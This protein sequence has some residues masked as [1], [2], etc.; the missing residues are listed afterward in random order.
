MHMQ[1]PFC[2]KNLYSKPSAPVD[3]LFRLVKNITNSLSTKIILIIASDFNINMQGS[4]SQKNN[5]LRFMQQHN[6]SLGVDK[7]TTHAGSML[8]HFWIHN[9]NHIAIKFIVLDTYWIDHF[10]IV[11]HLHL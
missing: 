6:L 5:L 9:L 1:T 3:N 8:D 2:I 4:T 10:A 11:L 7:P